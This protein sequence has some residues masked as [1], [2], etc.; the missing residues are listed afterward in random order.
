MK[1][2]RALAVPENGGSLQTIF[3]ITVV[4][5]EED[6]AVTFRRH[7]RMSI[8][9]TE[10]VKIAKIAKQDPTADELLFLALYGS[11]GKERCDKLIKS[12]KKGISDAKIKRVPQAPK[13]IGTIKTQQKKKT[14]QIVYGR[15]SNH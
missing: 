4:K 8:V 6:Y 1:Y 7:E 14:H 2:M 5:D 12:M 15:G 13:A 10:I 9:R 11:L 3:D